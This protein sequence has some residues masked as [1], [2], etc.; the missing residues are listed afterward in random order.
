MMRVLLHFIYFL[1]EFLFKKQVFLGIMGVLCFSLKISSKEIIFDKSFD[2]LPVVYHRFLYGY[3]DDEWVALDTQ[4]KKQNGFSHSFN[5]ACVYQF[6]VMIEHSDR[7]LEAFDVKTGVSLWKYTGYPIARFEIS[8]PYLLFQSV[9]GVGILDFYSGQELWVKPFVV[10]TIRL[11]PGVVVMQ[12]RVHLNLISPSKATIIKKIPI[13]PESLMLATWS[14]GCLLKEGLVFKSVDFAN[15]KVTVMPFKVIPMV[16]F[17]KTMA[18][19]SEPGL[20]KRV[21]LTTGQ[22]DILKDIPIFSKFWVSDPYLIL[23]TVNNKIKMYD[24]E[25]WEGLPMEVSFSDK[26]KE[27]YMLFWDHFEK[28]LYGVGLNW[29][30]CLYKDDV[31]SKVKISAQ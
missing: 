5:G 27:P 2:E 21:S 25:K 29:L 4:G 11:E 14:T 12:D 30:E 9:K 13:R 31:S 16:Y 18:I 15:G 24:L 23:K 6:N 26:I 8:V 10:S 22:V 7:G 19:L 3:W 17:R 20:L 1:R 28:R